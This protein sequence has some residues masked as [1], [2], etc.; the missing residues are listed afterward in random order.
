MGLTG[1]AD[2][3]SF[4]APSRPAIEGFPT[5]SGALDIPLPG[6]LTVRNFL[7]GGSPGLLAGA[8]HDEGAT[9]AILFG[10]TDEPAALLRGGE[11]MSALLLQATA[12][13]L[14]TAPISEAVERD[15]PRELL[16]RLLDGAGEPY[17]IVRLGY[18]E[19]TEAVP[20]SPRR[21][22]GDVIIVED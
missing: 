15:W 13:G 22:P 2:A 19:S 16:A 8:D 9:Y 4:P 10:A 7:P 6:R 21:A 12:E 17:L 18:V 3:P 5:L 11:A 1:A 14:A 20:P